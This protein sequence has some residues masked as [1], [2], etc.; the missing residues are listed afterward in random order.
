MVI[1]DTSVWI[2]ALRGTVNRQTVWLKRAVLGEEVGLTS[3]ILCEVLQGVKNDAQFRGLRADLLHFFI[4]DTGSAEL[5]IASAQNYQ[6]LRKKG[7]TVRKTIE[8]I[9]ATFCIE[10]GHRLLHR[11][12]DFEPFEKHLGLRVVHPPAI[13]PN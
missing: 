12:S 7:Y 6:T 5:A 9:I 11:D 8:C 2:D 1:V 4:F 10:E 3:L 13:A